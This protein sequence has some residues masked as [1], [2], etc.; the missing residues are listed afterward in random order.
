MQDFFTSAQ[1]YA[2]AWPKLPEDAAI[3]SSSATRDATRRYAI[4]SAKFEATSVL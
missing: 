2:S 4:G 1:A 3:S